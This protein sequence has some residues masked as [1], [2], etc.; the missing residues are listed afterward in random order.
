MSESRLQKES[1]MTQKK[2]KKEVNKH[3]NGRIL[4]KIQ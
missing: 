1:K 3:Q 2:K 4:E